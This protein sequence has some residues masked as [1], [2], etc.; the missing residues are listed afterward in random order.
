MSWELF[1]PHCCYFLVELSEKI[2][3]IRFMVEILELNAVS[4]LQFLYITKLNIKISNKLQYLLTNINI[5]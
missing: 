3:E 4:L 1:Y 5:K 2:N